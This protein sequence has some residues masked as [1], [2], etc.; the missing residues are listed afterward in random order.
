M[1]LELKHIAGYLPYGLKFVIWK[2]EKEERRIKMVA[3]DSEEN[4]CYKDNEPTFYISGID[5]TNSMRGN[6][7][8]LESKPIL[9]PLSDIGEEKFTELWSN[10]TDYE[11]ILKFIELDAETRLTCKFSFIFWEL[12]YENMFDIHDLIEKGLAIDINTLK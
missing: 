1:K 4:F 6:Y 2:G 12:L 11:S 10:E 3:I 8:I 7:G 5:E 9:R